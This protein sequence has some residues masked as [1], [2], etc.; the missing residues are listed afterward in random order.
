MTTATDK[1]ILTPYDRRRIVEF[2]NAEDLDAIDPDGRKTFRGDSIE[3]W[4]LT[5]RRRSGCNPT[6][7]NDEV[8]SV[9]R[10]HHAAARSIVEALETTPRPTPAEIVADADHEAEEAGENVRG[11]FVHIGELSAEPP[12]YLIRPFIETGSTAQLM[13]DPGSY[14]S[15]AAM[16]WGA[17]IAT[18]RPWMDC[19]VKSGPVLYVAGEGQRGIRRRFRAWEIANGADLT[20]AP[21]FVRTTPT[22]L[23]D[24]DAIGELRARIDEVAAEVGPPA[25]VI[26]DTLA[27]NYGPGDENSTADMTAAIAAVDRIRDLYGCAVLLV[28][29]V[30]H[31]DKS[32]GRGSTALKGAL[33][34]EYRTDKDEDG[35]MRL[36]CT[37]SKESEPPA[38]RAFNLATVELDMVDADGQPVTSAVLRETEYDDPDEGKTVRGA[39]QKTALHVLHGLESDARRN[40]VGDGRNADEARVSVKTWRDA[41]IASG[42]DRRRFSDVKRT[43]R[44]NNLIRYETGDYVSITSAGVAAAGILSGT[45]PPGPSG[46]LSGGT[47]VPPGRTDTYRQGPNRTNRTPGRTTG[48]PKPDR[49]RTLPA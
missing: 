17:S 23:T 11:R 31:G 20:E 49:G 25:M 16:D 15:F 41:C 7:T 42:M 33:D 43:L 2:L 5:I 29:H 30:G 4:T 32:R 26:L 34:V 22:A 3:R 46:V 39:N 37:K 1:S 10:D 13:G 9:W 27:R 19:P 21:L 35:T 6:A 38:P 36:F 48:H 44:D 14:K 40:I 8:L 45:D 28:H 18:G 47:T 24:P 12:D